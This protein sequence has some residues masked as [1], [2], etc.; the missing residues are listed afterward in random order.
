M[1]CGGIC[2]LLIL[3][4][5]CAQANLQ[6]MKCLT[7]LSDLCTHIQMVLTR[8]AARKFVY[9]QPGVSKMARLIERDKL[10]RS[11]LQ[12]LKFST[13]KIQGPYL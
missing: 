11:F 1:L 2:T 3:N 12:N 9:N 7:N 4:I 10:H 5:V 13:T 6:Q 8:A